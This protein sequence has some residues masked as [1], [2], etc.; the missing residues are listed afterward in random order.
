[1]NRDAFTG[2]CKQ[3]SAA[4]PFR[5]RVTTTRCAYER[6]GRV[7]YRKQITQRRAVRRNYIVGRYYY[8]TGQETVTWKGRTVSTPF[9]WRKDSWPTRGASPL[10]ARK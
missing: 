5:E 2:K 10:D 8:V 3:Y 7:E 6:T 1:M 4:S 9:A